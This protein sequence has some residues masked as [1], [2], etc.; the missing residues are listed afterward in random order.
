MEQGAV[1][2][3]ETGNIQEVVV[4]NLGGREVFIQA[5]DIIRGGMQDRVLTVSMILPPHS[6]DI[7]VGAFCVERGRWGRRG[8]EETTGFSESTARLP[9]QA[10]RMAIAEAIMLSDEAANTTR[11]AGERQRPE[12]ESLQ[13]RV[14]DSVRR[15]QMM[16]GR[17]LGSVVADE[18]SPSSLL[19]SFGNTAVVSALEEYEATLGKLSQEH[20]GAVGYVS[21]VNG[22]INSGDE[23]GSSEL[24]RKLW[25]R[26]LRAAA[27]EAIIEG[28][29]PIRNQLTPVEVAAFI[30]GA[31]SAEPISKPM[32][33]R[34]SL[35]TRKS[36]KAMYTEIRRRNGRWIH[37]SFVAY[38]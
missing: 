12:G 22:K 5:G 7:P 17:S 33:G 28:D 1:K 25:P 14:W 21:A 34:M 30:D 36:D 16:L 2:V 23:F 38:H 19:L 20:P 13:H 18:R 37:R 27:T 6:T 26:Q 32:P 15:T 35:E 24:F 9:S 4:R 11:A 10:G 8:R 31:R 3:G 29:V